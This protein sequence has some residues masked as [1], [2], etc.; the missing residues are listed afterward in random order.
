MVQNAACCTTCFQEATMGEFSEITIDGELFTQRKVRANHARCL[1]SK[2]SANRTLT[3]L[4]HREAQR[5]QACIRRHRSETDYTLLKEAVRRVQLMYYVSR[6]T[7]KTDQAKRAVALLTSSIDG[8]LSR[9]YRLYRQR[10]R[11]AFF[12]RR[13]PCN[14]GKTNTASFFAAPDATKN[15]NDRRA[16]S[17]K[18]IQQL[19]QQRLLVKFCHETFLRQR[20]AAMVLQGFWREL[21]ALRSHQADG[22]RNVI[23]TRGAEP[24]ADGKQHVLRLHQEKRSLYCYRAEFAASIIQLRVR[25]YFFKCS[26]RR[27]HAA[28]VL[29]NF[30]RQVYIL[31]L[32]NKRKAI[33]QIQQQKALYVLQKFGRRVLLDSKSA[34]EVAVKKLLKTID[35][36]S[37]QHTRD[38]LTARG[39]NLCLDRYALYVHQQQGDIRGNEHAARFSYSK[40]SWLDD[41]L[42]LSA[43][44]HNIAPRE[45]AFESLLSPIKPVREPSCSP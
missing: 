18:V 42:H 21:M 28:R 32:R 4:L 7:Q 26:F 31:R 43:Q 22:R 27:H 39:G 45:D 37:R 2:S 6:L 19:D 29:Q 38:L 11:A 23:A 8:Q 12:L 1:A 34:V 10:Q 33:V 41:S 35:A 25:K 40:S 24:F 17:V 36:S 13:Y 3:P 14:Q 44:A 5:I 16:V 9:S 30:A 20:F 15:P